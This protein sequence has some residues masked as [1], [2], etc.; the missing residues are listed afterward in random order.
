MRE[1]LKN[2]VN[3]AVCLEYTLPNSEK[4]IDKSAFS[5]REDFCFKS[6]NFED[7]AKIIYNGIVE[8]ALNEFE[9]DYDNLSLEQRK[10][11]STKMRY[12]KNAS[13]EEKQKYGFYGE[14]LIDLIL[15]CCIKTKV[16]LARGYL[17]SPIENAETKGFDAFHLMK[18][19]ENE[20]ELWLGEAKFYIQY[21]KPITDV[22]EKL[23]TSF[24][25]K[26]LQ[27]NLLAIIDE[28]VHITTPTDTVDEMVKA[29][30]ENPDVDLPALVK[31]HKLK[32]VYP[33]LI[34]YELAKSKTYEQNIQKCI[35]HINNEYQRLKSNLICE[36]EYSLFFIFLPVE[37][38]SVIKRKV[39]EWIDNREP[40]IL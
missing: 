23:T 29:W 17:Y 6:E 2:L 21:K 33:I 14:V 18:N 8:Y 20:D 3:N 5:T 11:I 7:I 39:F 22:L 28:S 30:N 26:Y 34:T 13:D 37:E 24:S 16:L 32:L 27:K 35:D 12:D 9:I 15:R 1:S 31:T 4:N 38:V 19:S 25:N 40:L 10:V 36:V